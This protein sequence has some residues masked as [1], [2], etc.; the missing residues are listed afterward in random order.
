[1]KT[2]KKNIRIP[3][4]YRLIYIA[5]LLFISLPST[6]AQEATDSLRANYPDYKVY[7]NPASNKEEAV[8]KIMEKYDEGWRTGDTEL[9]ASCLAIDAEWT[10]AFGNTKRGRE[11]IHKYFQWLFK[12]FNLGKDA[13]STENER[14]DDKEKS[15]GEDTIS[16]RHLGDDVAVL[17]GIG[18]T[19]MGNSPEQGIRKM[20]VTTVL[21]RQN[22]KWEIVHQMIMDERE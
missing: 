14:T 3:Q 15:R 18:F 16:V 2:S 7:G 19:T 5:I 1:M 9:A 20:H 10:N 11:D 13:A 17:H 4:A 12:K 21:A 22:G 6:L 8:W